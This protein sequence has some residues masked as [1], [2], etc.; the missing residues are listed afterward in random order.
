MSKLLALVFD[1]GTQSLR[2]SIF[3]KNNGELLAFAKRKYE[4]PYFS[5]QKNWAEQR[6]DFYFE[7]KGKTYL[8]ENKAS[9]ADGAGGGC[10]GDMLPRFSTLP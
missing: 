1:I 7:Y 4:Q 9:R 8:I 5:P 6:P 3:D 10:G 2:A